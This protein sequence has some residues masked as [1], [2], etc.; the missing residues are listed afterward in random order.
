MTEP[1]PAPTAPRRYESVIDKQWRL[2]QERGELEDLPGAGRPIPGAGEAPD[3]LW[4]VKGLIAREGLSTEPLLPTAVRL[5]KE[6]DR[7]EATLDELR[8][9]DEVRA[10]VAELNRRVTAHVR[11]P[12]GPPVRLA[13]VD[14]DDAV[15]G[16]IE[17]RP[18]PRPRPAPET[19]VIR[20]RWWRRRP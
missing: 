2:A 12:S 17:R 9:E 1:D 13:V 7:L 11:T 6:L 20:S 10:E 19:P 16:W 3:E 18:A 14:V 4:W 15:R 5:R 8:T